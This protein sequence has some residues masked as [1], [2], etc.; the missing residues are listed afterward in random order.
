MRRTARSFGEPSRDSQFS[1]RVVREDQEKAERAPVRNRSRASYV[2]DFASQN[3]YD[4]DRGSKRSHRAD[5]KTR[6]S[7]VERLKFSTG[8][9]IV[10]EAVVLPEREDVAKKYKKKKEI[11]L[12]QLHDVLIPSLISVGNLARLL[13]VRLGKIKEYVGWAYG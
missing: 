5:F 11:S 6:G 2:D 8:D 10:Q 7:I 3:R 12:S 1:N 4:D 9:E 13:E